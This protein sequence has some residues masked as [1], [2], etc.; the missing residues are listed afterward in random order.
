LI[1][2]QEY[3]ILFPFSPPCPFLPLHPVIAFFFLPSRTEVSS[4]EPFSLGKKF[5]NP[6]S[7]RGLI[8]KISKEFKKLAS[9][10]IKQHNQ[11]WGIELNREFTTEESPVAEKHL[12]KC[13]KS[14]VIREMQIKI[15]RTLRFYFT[16]IIMAKI[17]NTGDSSCW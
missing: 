14:L 8:F 4:V 17:K 5:P 15:K 12:K 7:S 2:P 9:K 11:K 3:L 13:S 16:L 10:T 6:T 1:P